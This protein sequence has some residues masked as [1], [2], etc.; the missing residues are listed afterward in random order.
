MLSSIYCI[1][2]EYTLKKLKNSLKCQLYPYIVPWLSL[3]YLYQLY[4]GPPKSVQILVT[5]STR[6][7]WSHWKQIFLDYL[8]KLRLQEKEC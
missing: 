4:M 8:A 7:H 5:V 3:I 2:M 6:G 1:Q